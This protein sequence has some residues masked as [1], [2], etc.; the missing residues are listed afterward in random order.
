M[1]GCSFQR[2][3]EI[4][5]TKVEIKRDTETYFEIKRQKENNDNKERL[6]NTFENQISCLHFKLQF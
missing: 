4:L 6:K 5:G 2:R 1:E 3:N